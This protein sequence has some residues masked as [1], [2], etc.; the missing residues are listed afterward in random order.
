[1]QYLFHSSAK[2]RLP[3]LSHSEE[4]LFDRRTKVERAFYTSAFMWFLYL[5][6]SRDHDQ[7]WEFIKRKREDTLS[8]KKAIRK[9]ERKHA[10]DQEK[11]EKT[12]TVKK[13]ERKHA[14]DQQVRFKKNR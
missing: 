10:L 7:R 14:L 4:K 12:I 9:K 5:F 2:C 6:C 11:K 1:M 8:T 13:K 3:F